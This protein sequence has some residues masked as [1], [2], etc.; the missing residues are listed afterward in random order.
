MWEPT[1]GPVSD[2]CPEDSRFTGRIRWVQLD[3]DEA[4]EDLDHLITG[5][6]AADRDGPGSEQPACHPRSW[7]TQVIA[8]PV[9][10]A[11]SG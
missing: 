3:I 7:K 10:E 6:A 11:V 2:D 8:S 1:A 9:A 4:A 5:G